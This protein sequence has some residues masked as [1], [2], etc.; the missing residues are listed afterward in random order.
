MESD[1]GTFGT[2]FDVTDD[3]CIDVEAACDV[4]DLLCK[5]GGKID[6]ETMAHVEHLVHLGPVGSRLLVD[7]AE[8][9]RNGEEIILDDMQV[10]DEVEH[11]GLCAT[12]AVYH[13]VEDGAQ[14]VR[15]V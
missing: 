6:F 5:L 13:A 7:G 4:D 10:L 14:R 15:G 2:S 1:L 8:Q 9:R 3:L 11:L 12:G